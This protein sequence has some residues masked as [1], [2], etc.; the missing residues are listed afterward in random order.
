[1]KFPSLAEGVS[2]GGVSF[3]RDVRQVV[4]SAD[5]RG[6]L[7]AGVRR[8]VSVA[9]GVLLL[10]ASAAYGQGTATPYAHGANRADAFVNSIGVVTHLT[11]TDTA[12]YAQW[13]QV[14][15][16]LQSLGVRHIRDGYYDW[17]PGTPFVSEHRQLAQLG[18]KTNYVVPYNPQ[19][20]AQSIA[21][22]A[23][24]VGDME[25][26]EDPNECDVAGNCGGSTVASSLLG[27]FNMMPV[28]DAAGEALKVPVLGPSFTQ[29]P[30]YLT[31]GNLDSTM[32]YN[33]LHVYFGGRYPGSM[34][35][36]A[37]DWLGNFYGSLAFW[38]NQASLDGPSTAT[39]VTETG[40]MSFPGQ[41]IP[42][43]IPESVE[44]SYIPRSLLL[45]FKA[46]VRRTYL[47]EL[48]D[49]PS[50]P[51]YGLLRSDLSPKPSYTAVQN[52]I[53]IFNDKGSNFTPGTLRYAT[54][55]GG[56]S[57]KQLLFEKRDG[58]FWLVLWLEQS[59]F[60][61]AHYVPTPV[62]SQ[63]VNLTLGAGYACWGIGS[64]DDT[65]NVTWTSPH[66]SGNAIPLTISDQITVVKVLAQ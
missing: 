45:A 34:G 14:L 11:Y 10:C 24:Q 38:L 36:G 3:C 17:E 1:M 18:I 43:T 48:L 44:A 39:M 28:I 51:G 23:S 42:Y 19:T 26:L 64:F 50:S 20:T 5:G 63:K 60:D 7:A 46:G 13:P 9:A 49:E 29:V 27:L 12:Y 55:G 22:I 16:A 33:N 8:R 41:S 47:Y 66:A 15:G 52:L 21:A 37:P 53:A 40:Y 6:C 61:T 31:V 25:S 62:T 4:A 54:A 58:S 32:S 59:S 57:L 56:S 2:F 35:W 65:G 30:T